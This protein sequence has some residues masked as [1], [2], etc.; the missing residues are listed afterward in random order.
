[1]SKI[2]EFKNDSATQFNIA[3]DHIRRNDFPSAVQ[4]LRNAVE[5]GERGARI[6]LGEAYLHSGL[7]VQAFETFVE[8]YCEGD[9]SGPCLFGL[10]RSSFLLGFDEDS[11]EYFKEIFYNNPTFA[12]TLPEGVVEELGTAISEFS[13]SNLPDKGFVFVGKKEQKEFDSDKI[14]MIRTN[15][16][17]ALPYFESFTP[18]S[19]LYVEARNYVA[20]IY[21][22]EGSPEI[23]MREC[24]EILSKE[25]DNLFA[26]S[27]LVVCYNA[28]GLSEKEENTVK[29]LKSIDVA[30]L[31]LVVK[32][33]LAMCQANRHAD[34]IEYFEKLDE[35]RYEKSS[36]I[37]LAIAYHNNGNTDK[38]KRT[39]RD[40]QKL[41]KKDGAYL[42]VLSEIMHRGA[43]KLD[44]SVNLSGGMALAVIAEVRSWFYLDGDQGFDFDRFILLM[45]SE[46]NYRL[47]QW[48]LTSG[49]RYGEE[50]DETML[51]RLVQTQDERCIGLV[52]E[53][54]RDF[55]AGDEIKCKCLRALLLGSY[56][57]EIQLLQGATVLLSKPVYPNNYETDILP[58]EDNAV[59][60]TDAFAY[61]YIKAFLS[62]DGFEKRL[63]QSAEEVRAKVLSAP[64]G[65]LRSPYALGAVLFAKAFEEENYKEKELCNIFAI[66]ESTLKKYTKYLSEEEKNEDC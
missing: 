15:P 62:A 16:E 43:S 13:E 31:D 1:M 58:G 45:R 37:L 49:V 26:M 42:T 61:A 30:D 44:Y 27:T 36:L 12:D 50:D 39:I 63:A 54:M 33:A 6:A 34:A 59:L 4:A 64:K 47:L 41:Y 24:E 32:I 22:L 5:L 2:L 40:A 20:L 21:L 25:E 3:E 17:R 11:A 18:S 51:F 57:R 28:L 65:Y 19:P 60:Y 35:R 56:G 52:K 55:Y 29:R 38:A 53:I 23:A 9:R 46:R 66:S 14:E 10:C 7:I 48:Y 8:A